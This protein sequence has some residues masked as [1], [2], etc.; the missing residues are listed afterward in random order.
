MTA[1]FLTAGSCSRFG[2][3][4]VGLCALGASAAAAAQTPAP[5]EIEDSDIAVLGEAGPKWLFL[6]S[7][8]ARPGTRIVDGETGKMKGM[9]HVAPLSNFG[10]DP[11]GKFFYVA[12]TMW[13][14]G[15]RGTRQDMIT[16]RDSQTLEVLDEIPLQGRLLVGFRKNNFSITADGRYGF[17]YN[18]NPASSIEVVDLKARKSVQVVEMPG[19]GVNA[20]L[21]GPRA[22][23]LCSNGAVAVT[24]FAADMTADVEYSEPFFSAD[25]APVFDSMVVDPKTGKATF[26][27]YTGQIITGDFSKGMDISQGW[28]LQKSVGLPA[29]STAPVLVNWLPGG[30]QPLAVHHA[31]GKAFVLMHIGEYWTQKEPGHEIWEI[32]L[33]AQKVIDRHP[34]PEGDEVS[35]MTI[36]QDAE[37]SLFL[38][39]TSS[40]LVVMNAATFEEEHRVKS[41]G[42]AGTLQAG[43]GQ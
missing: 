29:G 41:L 31:T 20:A 16:V 3:A 27:T 28:S 38:L 30:R 18:M 14:K 12:E 39:T 43:I 33:N 36:S 35:Q 24:S 1:S 9:V 15:N 26:L 13:T 6:T 19:C 21:P 11:E 5:L 34:M 4:M 25:Q 32:D 37:P 22:L 8:W 7:Q 2:R 42:A 17:V 40:D 10:A 23:S